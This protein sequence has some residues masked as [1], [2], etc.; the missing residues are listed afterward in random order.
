MKINRLTKTLIIFALYIASTTQSNY[1]LAQNWNEIMKVVASDR[2]ASDRYG[3]SVGI[4]GSY[5]IV[6]APRESHDTSGGN[7][8]LTAGSAYILEKI[9]GNWIEVQKLVASDRAAGDHFGSSVDISGNIAIIS[10]PSEDEDVTGG[11]SIQSTGSAY[12]FE[13]T[14]GVWTET[15]KIVAT[16]RGINDKFGYSVAISGDYAIVGANN[17]GHDTTGGNHLANSGSA[18]IFKN[19]GGVWTEVQKIIASDRGAF[20]IFGTTVDISGD[21]AIVG[22]ELENHDTL[23]SNSLY[24]SGSAYIF[25]NDGTSWFE[26]QKVVA[27]DRDRND[28]FGHSVAISRDYALIGA[29]GESHD[30]TGGNY[31]EQSGSAYIFKNNG[32]S[33]NEVQKLVASDRGDSDSF[34]KSVALS[35]DYAIISAIGESHDNTG[36]NTLQFSGSAYIF[37]NNAGTWTERQK[38]VAS[39]R[40]V[41]DRFGHAVDITESYALVS[42]PYEQHDTSGGNTLSFSG[43]SYI[44]KNCSTKEKD[45]R[46]ACD[47]LTWIDGNTYKKSNNT[48]TYS[49]T[50][51]AGCDSIITLNLTISNSASYDTLTVCKQYTWS[52][53]NITYNSSGTYFD[54]LTNTAGCDSILTLNLTIDSVSNLSTTRSG[55][56]ISAN[57]QNASYQWLECNYGFAILNGETG[58]TFT[59]NMNGSYAVELTEN[60]CVDTSAC[61][62]ITSV[63]LLEYNFENTLKTYPNPTKGA[64]RIEL[65][66]SY[67]DLSVIIRN[68]IGQE[69]SRT[70]YGSTNLLP[71]ELNGESGLYFVEVISVD[72]K[73]VLKVVKE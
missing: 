37:K 23:G 8:L 15:Q 11:N 69:V 31:I 21:Y 29:L 24:N 33:W 9:G 12:I 44:F 4:S 48:A 55:L 6:G 61:I 3:Y 26:V 52:A 16:D 53:N 10:S 57:N 43:S 5:A 34:G 25:K 30:T 35:G 67:E 40:D 27:S 66:A 42:T 36:G 22:A 60:G 7:Y 46:T 71:I 28:K 13:R 32:S 2:G 59:A 39:D 38:I 1:I 63:G 49:L 14:T 64:I 19:T 73:A 54:T 62:T 68:Q 51:A 58:Q 72:K 70:F 41:Y 65:G 47:S 56:T 18:Y 17:D 20:D 50:N 45:L